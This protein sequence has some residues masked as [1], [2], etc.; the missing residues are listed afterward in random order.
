MSFD[1]FWQIRKGNAEVST[2]MFEVVFLSILFYLFH[3]FVFYSFS[4]AYGV[5]KS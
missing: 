3:F 4:P 5:Q 2:S 1:Q